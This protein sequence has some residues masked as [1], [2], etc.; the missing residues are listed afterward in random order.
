M[1]LKY[2]NHYSYNNQI[3]ISTPIV[4]QSRNAIKSKLLLKKLINWMVQ[5]MNNGEVGEAWGAT[6][7]VLNE[8][9][10]CRH[11]RARHNVVT[12]VQNFPWALA[13]FGKRQPGHMMA[14]SDTA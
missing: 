11:C 5:L 12:F 3:I 9:V 10:L 6:H 1:G 13:H 7:V 14:E 4:R 2:Y 8:K